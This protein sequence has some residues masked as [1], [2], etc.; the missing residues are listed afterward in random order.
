MKLFNFTVTNCKNCNKCVRECPVKAIRFINNKAEIDDEKCIACG[1]CFVACPM[2][3]RNVENDVFNVEKAI[4]EGKNVVACVDSAYLGAFE[5]PDKFVGALKKMGFSSVQEAA[6]GSEKITREYIKY[7]NENIGKQKYF[8]SSTCPAIY[9]FV[10]KYHP[11]LIQYLIP[12]DMPVMAIA[13]AVKEE[14]KDAI[15]V[16]VGQCLSKKNEIKPDDNTYLNYH[17]TFDEVLKML[18]KKGIDM[19]TTEGTTP[20]RAARI[21]GVSYSIA[22]DMWKNI[23][24]FSAE[25]GYDIMRVDGMNSIK[26]LFS[27]ME[28]GTLSKCYVGVSACAESCINGPFMPK[29]APDLF[30]RRQKIR[31][32]A[33][34]GWAD[35]GKEF[36]W[37]KIDVSRSFVEQSANRKLA[38]SEEIEEIL[39][40]MGKKTRADEF[41]CGACGY[42]SCREKAQGVFEGMA[43]IEM[44]WPRLREKA[45]RKGDTIFENARNII[46]M[47]DKDLNVMQINPVAERSFGIKDGEIAG[48]SVSFLNIAT[49]TFEEAMNNKKDILNKKMNLEEY[50]ITVMCNTVYIEGDELFVSMQDI[51]AE[52]RRKKELA[53]L[54]HH[55]VEIAQNV[56]EKQMRVA[57]EIA[58]LMGETT[59]ET[60]VALNR[61]KD[62]MLKEESE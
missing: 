12:V 14:D 46:L 36:D 26:Q 29:D 33:Q 60:K 59:A 57:Q 35:K 55:S 21:S 25:H 19:K 9:L 3:A 47:L 58:S 34:H 39:R 56:I 10:E 54:K 43:D 52:E 7:L 28:K 41:D 45:K 48:S 31:N 1:R 16:Y 27:S 61:L 23:K 38:T 51:T 32:F 22:G 8:I 53:E 24:T 44:C 5:E 15:V 40:K 17:I 18:V 50:G 20:D 49:D 4:E 13:K 42:E 2:H 11:Q 30:C 62:V 37:D 6:A